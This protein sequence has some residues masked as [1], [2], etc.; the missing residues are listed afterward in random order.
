MVYPF[1]VKTGAELTDEAVTP[2]GFKLDM[3]KS[4]YLTIDVQYA[5][6]APGANGYVEDVRFNR[7]AK[8]GDEYTDEGIYTF[9]VNNLF[10]G[11]STT[12][13]IYV[14]EAD[15]LMALSVNNLS[16]SDLNE[17]IASGAEI[18][19][20]GELVAPNTAEAESAGTSA[21]AIAST[22]QEEQ[23]T[24]LES[25]EEPVSSNEPI[26]DEKESSSGVMFLVGGTVCLVVGVF[27]FLAVRSK[28]GKTQTEE[29]R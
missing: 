10:T 28:K 3:A 8:D 23:I 9:S 20:D 2:N 12:K 29:G 17:R 14:G 15:Y 22:I 18:Q 19:S 24:S 26:K 1:D 21:E 5:R 25:Q 16:V 13:R 4:K 27:A 7:P 11:E 6:V